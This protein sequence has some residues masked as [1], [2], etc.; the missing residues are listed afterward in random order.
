MF[1]WEGPLTQA[2]CQVHRNL[3][4]LVTFFIHVGLFVFKFFLLIV[5]KKDYMMGFPF[6][7]DGGGGGG[8]GGAFPL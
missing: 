1:R 3:A 4:R 5:L 7:D 6:P 2:R 8:G